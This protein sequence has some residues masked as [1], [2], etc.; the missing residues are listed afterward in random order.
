MIV[1]DASALSMVLLREEGWEKVEL[2]TNTAIPELAIVETT[3]AIWKALIT[4]RIER[5][6]A[7]ERLK[8]LQLIIKGIKVLGSDGFLERTLEIAVEEKITVYDALYIAIAESLSAKLMTSD[9][10]QCKIAKKYVR[11]ELV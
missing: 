3:N 9:L 6:D 7:M 8:A 2:S 10:K 5:N 1:L 11:T 4:G